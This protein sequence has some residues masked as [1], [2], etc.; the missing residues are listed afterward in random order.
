ME[1]RK[2]RSPE[3]IVLRWPRRPRRDRMNSAWYNRRV[4]LDTATPTDGAMKLS[5]VPLGLATGA[6]MLKGGVSKRELAAESAEGM[7][8]MAANAV[9][10]VK[11]LGPADFGKALSTG[12]IA[13]GAML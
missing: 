6:F 10:Q 8:S 12:E 9:P 1:M 4:I 7:V 2:R 13:R 3:I 5:H 11:N